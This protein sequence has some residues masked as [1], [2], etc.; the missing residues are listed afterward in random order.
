MRGIIVVSVVKLLVNIL[1]WLVFIEVVDEGS[2]C[3][4]AVAKDA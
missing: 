4:A 2:L 3:F 1:G